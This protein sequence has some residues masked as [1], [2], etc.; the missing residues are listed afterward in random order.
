MRSGHL[1][2]LDRQGRS[3]SGHSSNAQKL[4]LFDRF[5]KSALWSGRKARKTNLENERNFYQQSCIGSRRSAR[6][7]A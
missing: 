7:L 5:L 1:L 4:L 3:W 6:F 2:D